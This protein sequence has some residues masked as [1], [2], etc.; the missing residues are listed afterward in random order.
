MVVVPWGMWSIHY[1]GFAKLLRGFGNN[2]VIVNSGFSALLDTYIYS[3]SHTLLPLHVRPL[4]Y[5]FPKLTEIYFHGTIF[6]C[7]H[8]FGFLTLSITLLLRT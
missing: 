2:A 5:L 4:F 7:N 1:F 8:L 6:Y 3:L